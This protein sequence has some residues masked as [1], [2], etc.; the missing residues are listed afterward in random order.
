MG[1]DARSNAAIEAAVIRALATAEA[2]G[3]LAGAEEMQKEGVPFHVAARVML[4]PSQRRAT[5]RSGTAGH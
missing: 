2:K 3:W 4:Y 5:D 1:Y